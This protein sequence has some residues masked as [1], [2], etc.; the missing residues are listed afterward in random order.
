MGSCA[1]KANSPQKDADATET[2]SSTSHKF[3]EISQF[4]G[5]LGNEVQDVVFP[6]AK[7]ASD[8]TR[9]EIS[10]YGPKHGLSEIFTKYTIAD[11]GPV[12]P[13]LTRFFLENIYFDSEVNDIYVLLTH[14][15]ELPSSEGAGS[16]FLVKDQKE[17]MAKFIQ[18]VLD[19]TWFLLDQKPFV[20]VPIG[21]TLYEGKLSN[22]NA[23]QYDL[24]E[25]S[26]PVGEDLVFLPRQMTMLCQ[27]LMANL[28]TRIPLA[29]ENIPNDFEIQ[30]STIDEME[31]NIKMLALEAFKEFDTRKFERRERAL[32]REWQRRIT[33]RV[34]LKFP[35][36]Q[37]SER[38][39][40][41]IEV[42][43]FP[44]TVIEILPRSDVCWTKTFVAHVTTR[45]FILRYHIHQK[46]FIR[47]IAGAI[48]PTI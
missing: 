23:S 3:Q 25:T 21:M 41:T 34:N 26:V 6:N 18:L 36:L 5:D 19:N 35:R 47:K 7:L 15:F 9:E 27:G 1:G 24:S 30:S 22:T 14:L 20:L 45:H 17:S 46:S 4:A 38:K 10:R 40:N 29:F 11:C 44:E 28:A 2:I 37:D 13:D 43:E 12:P 8:L 16:Y 32:R 42:R 31:S 48:V 39:L 33:A